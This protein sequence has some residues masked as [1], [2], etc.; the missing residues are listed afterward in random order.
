M[1]TKAIQIRSIKFIIA[2]ISWLM[3]LSSSN[4]QGQTQERP[5]IGPEQKKLEIWV[6]DWSYEGTV[7]ETPLGPS[8]KYAGKLNYR[9]ILDGLFLENRGEDKGVY[10]GKEMTYK[11]VSMQ[12]YNP[13]TKTY[14]VQGYDNDS[15]VSSSV[16]TVNGSTWTRIGGGTT[17]SGKQTKVKGTLTFGPD[18]KSYTS[19][20]ELSLDDG[21]TWTPYWDEIGKKSVRQ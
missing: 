4:L 10:G 20:G 18:G 13:A 8:G 7:K 2:A 5:T 1:Q 19:K 6:G 9:F 12:W 16:S 15:V 17:Q 11:Y 14:L 21:K 3:V